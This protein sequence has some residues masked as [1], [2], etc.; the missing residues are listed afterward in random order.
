[1]A[2]PKQRAIIKVRF[3]CLVG[4]LNWNCFQVFRKY[5]HSLGP[6]AL[7]FVEEVLERHEIPDD[8]VEQSVEWIA[9]EYNKQDGECDFRLVFARL[10]PLQMRR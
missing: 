3:K 7:E 2:G 9:K 4:D 6:E 10:I 1:M 8:Q 5:S